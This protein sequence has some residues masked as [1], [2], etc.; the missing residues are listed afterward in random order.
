M[1]NITVI[2]LIQKHQYQQNIPCKDDG[3]D[4]EIYKMLLNGKQVDGILKNETRTKDASS[5]VQQMLLEG[6]FQQTFKYRNEKRFSITE[7]TSYGDG[8]LSAGTCMRKKGKVK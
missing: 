7:N 3:M 2:Y 4:V 1:F 5:Q 6:T 8:F